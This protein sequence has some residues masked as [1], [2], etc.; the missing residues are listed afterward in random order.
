MFDL[1]IAGESTMKTYDLMNKV[2]VCM[3]TYNGENYIKKQIESILVQLQL[4]DEIIISDDGSSDNTLKV[5][6]DFQDERIKIFMNKTGKGVNSNFENALMQA[7]GDII[8]LSD[9]DDIWLPHKVSLCSDALSYFD[10]VVSN[11]KVADDQGVVIQESYFQLVGSGKGILKNIYRS[12]YL[13][14][15][16]SF[17]RKILNS[18]LPIPKSL[19]L[20]HDW[21]FGFISEICFKV[22]FIDVPCMLYRR[23]RLSTST[24][25]SKSNFNLYRKIAFRLQLLCLG[26]VRVFMIKFIRP[27]VK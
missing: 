10:L 9:Q 4:N 16:L 24:T 19:F 5:V 12:S 25:L 22:K 21:W 20:Y 17:K 7:S 1:K 11:C 23:H 2:S 14:C 18:I 26:L 27:T 13:G 6:R 15:C 3:A 8:F